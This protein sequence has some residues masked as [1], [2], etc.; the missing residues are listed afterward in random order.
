MPYLT[1]YHLSEQEAYAL[2][3]PVR[4]ALGELERRTGHYASRLAMEPAGR[5]AVLA[6]HRVLATARQEIEQLW[7]VSEPSPDAPRGRA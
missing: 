2:L 7:R 5:E 6:A 3:G 1:N 4:D